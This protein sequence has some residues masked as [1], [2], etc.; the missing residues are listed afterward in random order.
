MDFTQTDYL[1]DLN[2]DFG[3]PVLSESSK[4]DLDVFQTDFFDFEGKQ[5][6]T[7]EIGGSDSYVLNIA[8]FVKQENIE[9][10][11]TSSPEYNTPVSPL[12]SG[13]GSGSVRR[14][15]VSS[16]KRKRNTE[17]S[18][19]FRIKKKMKEQEMERQ[20]KELRER[21]AALE[22]TIKTLDMENKCL[23]QLIL[24][25]N[26]EKNT[27]L[28]DSIKRRSILESRPVFQYTR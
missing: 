23:K 26:E 8:P 22:K 3:S 28:L 24:Q 17:A 16:E 13:S 25:R 5:D 2:L 19:R 1:Q 4:S 15:T 18:A 11:L 6:K 14:S 20:Q 9:T 12:S 21:M 10:L 27:D 7:Y